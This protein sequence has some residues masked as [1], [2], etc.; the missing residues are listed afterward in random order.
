MITA[1]PRSIFKLRI[2]SHLQQP[3]VK[4]ICPAI[5]PTLSRLKVGNLLCKLSGLGLIL[6][7]VRY[8]FVDYNDVKHLQYPVLVVTAYGVS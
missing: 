5:S 7:L 4:H 2:Q 6:H 1:A 8:S 3:P